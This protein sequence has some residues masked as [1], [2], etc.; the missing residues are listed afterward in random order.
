M[1]PHLSTFDIRNVI[2]ISQYLMCGT[3]VTHSGTIKFA[4]VKPQD[5]LMCFLI[6][7]NLARKTVL[8]LEMRKIRTLSILFLVHV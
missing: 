5:L 7:Q 1:V 6:F 3:Y 8:S 4:V 2:D